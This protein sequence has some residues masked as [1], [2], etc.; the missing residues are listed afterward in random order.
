MEILFTKHCFDR[1]KERMRDIDSSHII[2]VNGR[3]LVNI[4]RLKKR[5][6]KVLVS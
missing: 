1:Y 4:E 6:K 5:Y 2:K 3:E